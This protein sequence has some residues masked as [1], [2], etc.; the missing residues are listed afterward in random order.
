MDII[1]LESKLEK[2]ALEYVITERKQ[3]ESFM[4]SVKEN[5]PNL[6]TDLN[7]MDKWFAGLRKYGTRWAD[8]VYEIKYKEKK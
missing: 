4:K 2:E 5:N 3:N 6:Y 8:K 7:S 1:E